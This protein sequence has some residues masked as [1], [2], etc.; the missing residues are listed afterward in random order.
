MTI[1]NHPP[2]PDLCT[3]PRKLI[4]SPGY[5]VAWFQQKRNTWRQ[6][7]YTTKTRWHLKQDSTPLI[8]KWPLFPS[9]PDQTRMHALRA[10]RHRAT[11]GHNVSCAE[12]IVRGNSLRH[13]THESAVTEASTAYALPWLHCILLYILVLQYIA[14]KQWQ[15]TTLNTLLQE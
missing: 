4:V 7:T 13:C 15:A 14:E 5:W 11:M 10:R 1:T 9:W 12:L 6:H 3:K 2:W 8:W